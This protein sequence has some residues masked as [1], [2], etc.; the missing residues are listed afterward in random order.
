MALLSVLQ[1]RY[2]ES[3]AVCSELDI[4]YRPAR[5]V[6]LSRLGGPRRNTLPKS[7]AAVSDLSYSATV[8][9]HHVPAREERRRKRYSPS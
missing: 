7:L 6:A 2:C 3:Y 5:R 1:R 8:L 4:T 9:A